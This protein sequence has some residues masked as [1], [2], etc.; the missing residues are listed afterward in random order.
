M[1]KEGAITIAKGSWGLTIVAIV[2]NV[3][4]R[5]LDAQTRFYVAVGG[6]C[7]Y[8]AG[9]LAGLLALGLIFRFGRR[10]ILVHALIGTI[11]NSFL[12]C[13]M[14]LA[15]A[16]GLAAKR[17]SLA[18]GAPAAPRAQALEAPP[19]P[20]A[21]AMP[22]PPQDPAMAASSPPRPFPSTPPTPMA[23]VQ[24]PGPPPFPRRGPMRR[25]P[26]PLSAE[27]R[28]ASTARSAAMRA[29]TM[30]AAA[31]PHFLATSSNPAGPQSGEPVE[32]LWGTQWIPATVYRQEADGAY[33]LYE[34]RG[35]S[36][37][38]WV[39]NSKLR[40]ASIKATLATLT[41]GQKVEA[42]RSHMVWEAGSV[43]KKDATRVLVHYD[44]WSDSVNEWLAP[45]EI[46]IPR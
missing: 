42:K 40:K 21:H 32:T 6:M 44:G 16:I 41:A 31:R 24:P 37:A 33:I 34:G 25:G 19:M 5:Q 27:G 9:L 38:E 43:V 2:L 17:R 20:A 28:A 4:S 18:A 11:A 14:A 35:T 29:A 3:A 12:V 46:R 22:A 30:R 13:L 7:L 45:D 23:N 39:D 8:G 10:G 26:G 15:I 1:E 36:T